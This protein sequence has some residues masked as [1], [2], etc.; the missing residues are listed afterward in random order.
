MVWGYERSA[1]DNMLTKL[2]TSRRKKDK[3][4]AEP[5]EK[6]GCLRDDAQ[7]A[8]IKAAVAVTKVS[9]MEKA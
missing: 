3:E 6:V 9:T 1:S 8:Q 2:R 7:H 5:H 4:I